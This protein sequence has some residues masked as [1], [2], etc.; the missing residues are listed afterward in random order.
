MAEQD[1]A[2]FQTALKRAAV[3]FKKAG[4][5]ESIKLVSNLDADGIS[6]AS[7]MIR[8]I[9]RLGF[10]YSLTILHQLREQDIMALSDEDFKVFVFCD[11]GSG[12]LNHLQKHL[13]DRKIFVLDH[14]EVQGKPGK[15]TLQ[16][17]P[18]D[19]GF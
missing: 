4:A 3:E 16:I 10:S 19:Y 8:T 12:Q 1:L 17:N 13:E 11:L 9:E 14:H 5:K 2:G 7:I 6:A 18:H 15:N